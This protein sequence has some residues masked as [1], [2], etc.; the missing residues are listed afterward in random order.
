MNHD[1]HVRSNCGNPGL[2]RGANPWLEPISG[3]FRGVARTHLGVSG[4]TT[5]LNSMSGNHQRHYPIVQIDL[6][7]SSIFCSSSRK[8]VLSKTSMGNTISYSATEHELALGSAKGTIKA[9]QYDSKSRRYAG[10][11]YALPP[12]GS[13]RW[14]KPHPLPP[15]HSYSK[16]DGHH[17]RQQNSDQFVPRI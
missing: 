3:V 4:A 13:R 7:I 12:T 16:P 1:G 11:P 10:I 17:L 6:K 9:L 14:Q 15:S 8:W 5:S 2:I